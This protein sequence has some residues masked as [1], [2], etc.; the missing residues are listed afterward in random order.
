MQQPLLMLGLLTVIF[1]SGCDSKTTEDTATVKPSA[2]AGQ[3]AAFANQ[4]Q[5]LEQAKDADQNQE[6]TIQTNKQQIDAQTR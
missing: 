1:T 5:A 4:Q 2:T 3:P 6:N